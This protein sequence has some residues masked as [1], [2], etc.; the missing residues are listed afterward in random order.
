M[1]PLAG[2]PST[3]SA[4]TPRPQVPSRC[5]LQNS[6]RSPRAKGP[7]GDALSLSNTT[8]ERNLSSDKLLRTAVTLNRQPGRQNDS[9]D[10]RP[11]PRLSK[12]KQ[13]LDRVDLRINAVRD[14]HD[15]FMK[16]GEEILSPSGKP[17]S[18]LVPA[19]VPEPAAMQRRQSQ[20]Q[21]QPLDI[22]AEEEHEP[23]SH[24]STMRLSRSQR[25]AMQMFDLIDSGTMDQDEVFATIGTP[26][27]RV[28]M[29]LEFFRDRS[30]GPICEIEERFMHQDKRLGM[31]MIDIDKLRS[32]R[33]PL[34]ATARKPTLPPI[35]AEELAKHLIRQESA[36]SW[37]ECAAERS[38][39]LKSLGQERD[40]RITA[41]RAMARQSDLERR[42]AQLEQNQARAARRGTADRARLL[43]KWLTV[44]GSFH[45]MSRELRHHLGDPGERQRIMASAR[46]H[47]HWETARTLVMAEVAE[48]RKAV[49]KESFARRHEQ[50][51]TLPFWKKALAPIMFVAKLRRAQARSRSVDIMKV[52]IEAA[53][54][55]MTFRKQ[56]RAY[57]N[58]V[59]FLQRAA[60]VAIKFRNCVKQFVYFPWLWEVET[61]IL[62]EKL[63]D[64]LPHG[65]T[66]RM[67]ANHRTHWNL[68]ARL[69][70]LR[71][72]SV[73]RVGFQFSKSLEGKMR[74]KDPIKR[75]DTRKHRGAIRADS[76]NIAL[77]SETGEAMLPGFESKTQPHFVLA[78]TQVLDKYRLPL[79]DRHRI[80]GALLRGGV[81]R[82]WRAHLDYK[83]KKVEF[84]AA[85]KAWLIEVQALGPN[86]RDDWQAF[87]PFPTM[88][89]LIL[90]CDVARLRHMVIDRLKLTELG[91]QLFSMKE[92]KDN[93]PS[94]R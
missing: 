72:I 57:L 70:D 36:S 52:F 21:Q 37:L 71:K 41:H 86:A 2:T 68:E 65:M 30:E 31:Q 82:W 79:E 53:W 33:E 83:K 14:N 42:C 87:P 81:D 3:L 22:D 75:K 62:S 23:S 11:T 67:I 63:G 93:K 16:N 47:K 6:F 1:R 5:V 91:Q 48:Q 32:A 60:M 89:S 61:Q 38:V 9:H 40:Q 7:D 15:A 18:V 44:A 29:R 80:L 50:L 85:W 39:R 25:K 19:L 49:L 10:N 4:R 45:V 20:Q 24:S 35:E 94:K 27:Q 66:K 78:A 58:N 54:K 90:E 56:M 34:R 84:A 17:T 28:E 59:R 69:Q 77:F 12:M 26:L 74:A 76:W 51:L 46:A 88:P 8:M 64:T 73:Q 92:M 43:L 55:G 13:E